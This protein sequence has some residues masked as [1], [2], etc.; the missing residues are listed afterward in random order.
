MKPWSLATLAVAIPLFAVAM[1]GAIYELTSPHWL[2]WHVVLRKA[3][4]IGAFMLV[5]YLLRR[6]LAEWGKRP[7]AALLPG[8]IAL[9]SASIEV[10]QFFAGSREGLGWNAFDTAC[11][12]LGGALALALPVPERGSA[13]SRPKRAHPSAQP[14]TVESTEAKSALDDVDRGSVDTTASRT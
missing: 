8:C 3:Y 14:H 13:S 11:G 5:G 10:G 9:Y 2:S 7:P 4:S 1:S 6:A 12:A